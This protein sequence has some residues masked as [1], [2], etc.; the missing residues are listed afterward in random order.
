MLVG[1]GDNCIDRYLSP[2]KA[3]RVGGN[4]LNVAANI[5]IRGEPAA[6]AGVVGKDDDGDWVLRTLRMAGIDTSCVLQVEGVT[7]VTEIAI[8]G[9]DY[10]ILREEYGVSASVVMTDVLRDFILDRATLLHT[11]VAGEAGRLLPELR[12]FGVPLSVDLGIVRSVA[13]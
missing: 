1:I 9:G 8:D 5:A 11:T 6:Y 13:A 3:A 12:G 10:R 4:A 7:G 2:I